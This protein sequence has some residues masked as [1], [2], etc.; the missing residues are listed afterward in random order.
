MRGCEDGADDLATAYRRK[1][2][3]ITSLRGRPDLRPQR[4]GHDYCLRAR[5]DVSAAR[6]EPPRWL[7]ARLNRRLRQIVLHPYGHAPLSDRPGRHAVGI[8]RLNAYCLLL[9]AY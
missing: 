2:L 8:L 7:L 9:T 4:R 6:C 3:R 1:L 5:Q